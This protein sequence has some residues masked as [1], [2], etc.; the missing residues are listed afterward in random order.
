MAEARVSSRVLL[1]L[2][3][4]IGLVAA[5][6]VSEAAFVLVPRG[7]TVDVDNDGTRPVRC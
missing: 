3:S 1:V 6:G 5:T 4:V 7:G 2:S